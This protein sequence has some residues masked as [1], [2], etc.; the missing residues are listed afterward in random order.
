MYVE[1]L[2]GPSTVNTMPPQ[3]VVVF[4]DHDKVQ[5]T[6]EENLEEAHQTLA[7][8]EALGI[9]MQAVTRELEE[10]GVAS[11]P[12][13]FT[14]LLETV[15]AHRQAAA[16]RGRLTRFWR[17]ITIHRTCPRSSVDRAFACG[18]KGRAFESRRGR[19]YIGDK[20]KPTRKYGGRFFFLECTKESQVKRFSPHNLRRMFVSHLLEEGAD[21]AIV[22]KMAGHASVQ[23]TVRN[24]RRPEEAKRK[25]ANLLQVPTLGQCLLSKADYMSILLG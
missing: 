24:D 2:I 14:V 11:F 21:I 15:E 9:S 25:A 16:R 10:E 22:S 7:D 13:A 3:T 5:L 1:G 4:L 20:P 12:G 8:L 19:L 18:A 23:T 17:S 6:L